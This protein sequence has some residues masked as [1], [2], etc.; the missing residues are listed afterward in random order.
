MRR[1]KIVETDRRTI[2]RQL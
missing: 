2:R 1:A